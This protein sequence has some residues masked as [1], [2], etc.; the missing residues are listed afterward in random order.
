MKKGLVVKATDA[1]AKHKL[2]LV[3]PDWYYTW[4]TSQ[5][6]L[7]NIPFVP[8]IW[9]MSELRVARSIR[10]PHLLLFNEP[11]NE[12]QSHIDPVTAA[13]L[14]NS[15]SFPSDMLIGSPATASNPTKPG[16]WLS[17]F[18][19]EA[20][21]VDFICMHW[22]AAPHPQSLVSTIDT[23]YDLYK[24]PIWITE[25][26]VA[27]WTGNG[28]YTSAQVVEFM[29]AILP[30]LDAHPHVAR[31]CWKTRSQGDVFMGP[32]ALFNDI[33]GSLTELGK[34]YAKA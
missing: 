16:G 27:D 12:K 5:V 23:L 10:S 29:Q 6:A 8:M 14:F 25:F 24:K 7:T 30:I 33:D 26:A 1:L 20:Q 19:S 31:Y 22:Y 28:R 4:G 9:G 15:V 34:V 32:S 11:D 2:D 17:V 3:Q 18:M 13:T 21:P